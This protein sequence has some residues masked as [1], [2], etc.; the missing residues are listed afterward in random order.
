LSFKPKENINPD[1]IHKLARFLAWFFSRRPLSLE[2]FVEYMR[3]IT[4]EELDSEFAKGLYEKYCE[5][6]EKPEE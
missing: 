5:E 1:S 6:I 2:G 3:T 4:T